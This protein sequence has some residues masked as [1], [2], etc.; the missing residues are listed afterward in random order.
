MTVLYHFIIP[1]KK[2]TVKF[3]NHLLKTKSNFIWKFLC[4]D[5]FKKM[6]FIKS[7]KENF[8]ELKTLTKF[9]I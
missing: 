1:L 7:E 2:D 5:I 4:N 3:E 6:P 8:K 9:L